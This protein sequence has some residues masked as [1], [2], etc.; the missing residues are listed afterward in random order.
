MLG[1]ARAQQKN[2]RSRGSWDNDLS[3]ALQVGSEVR[4]GKSRGGSGSLRDESPVL[5]PSCALS[6]TAISTLFLSK[7]IYVL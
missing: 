5:L 2:L 1:G 6:R 4:R 7:F 3:G